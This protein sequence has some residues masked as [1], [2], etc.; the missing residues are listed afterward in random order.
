MEFA[1]ILGIAVVLVTIAVFEGRQLRAHQR[2][3]RYAMITL[4]ILGGILAA[5]LVY[6]MEMPGPTQFIETVYRPLSE[7]FEQWAEERSLQP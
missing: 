5:M 4:C 1:T 7:A 2:R 3:E 6:N